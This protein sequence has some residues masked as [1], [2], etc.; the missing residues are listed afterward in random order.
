MRICLIANAQAV[1]TQRW[2]T[3]YKAAGHEVAVVSIRQADIPGVRVIARHVGPLNTPSRLWTL[4]SY[5]WLLFDC[6]SLLKR[7]APDVVHAHYTITHGV[8]AAFSGFHPRA[9]TAWGS[10]VIW[11]KSGGMSWWRRVFNRIAVTRADFLTSASG[12]MLEHLRVLAPG[13]KHL[14]QIPFGVDPHLFKPAV[15]LGKGRGRTDGGFRI[16]FVKS[17]HSRYGPEVLLRAMPLVLAAIPDA[18]LTMAGRGPLAA[19]LHRLARELG[20]GDRV[21]FPGFVPNHELPE[22]LRSFDAFVNCA[23]VPESFGV[24]VLEASACGLPVVATRV[25]GVPEVCRHAETGL[26]VPAND[27]RA[28]AEALI[29]LARD[30]GLRARLGKA[31]RRFVLRDYT[32]QSNV[33]FMLDGLADLTGLP[34][35][36]AG[37]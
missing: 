7:L 25:G 34:A 33:D 37:A 36:G 30:A 28:L 18:H 35:R 17:L 11:P 22:L 19:R 15:Q 20:I 21:E 32:W 10:D 5:L 4:L 14:A 27:A 3:A 8:I 23:V 31:G 13:H 24:A 29:G 2:A 16:G 1:H 6:R 12:F 26:L 9:V